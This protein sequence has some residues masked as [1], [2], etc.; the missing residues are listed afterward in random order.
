MTLYSKLM[1]VKANFW[2]NAKIPL[3]IFSINI[4]ANDK[5]AMV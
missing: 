5:N 2:I 1:S 3:V 4:F